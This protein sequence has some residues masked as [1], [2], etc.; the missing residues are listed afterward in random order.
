MMTRKKTPLRFS[1]L[2]FLFIPATC[3][4]LFAFAK[5]SIRSITFSNVLAED[6]DGRW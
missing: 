4:L 1:L 6:K 2:Y 5:P 3:L